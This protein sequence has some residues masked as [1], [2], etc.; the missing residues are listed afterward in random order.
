MPLHRSQG[1]RPDVSRHEGPNSQGR[2]HKGA[3]TECGRFEFQRTICSAR[4]TGVLT[5]LQ[6]CYGVVLEIVSIMLILLVALLASSFLLR[7][8]RLPLPFAQIV[9]GIVL[10][11]VANL[12]VE[13]NP[14]IFFL[15]FLP[16]LLFIDG[17][18]ISRTWRAAP[19]RPRAN[20]HPAR[21][22]LLRSQ[23]CI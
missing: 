11:S 10:G 1:W 22:G 21:A 4:K 7:A 19:L 16:A 6:P 14:E 9:V 23:S 3:H 20:R 13:L 18:R 17:W 15:L 8:S 12:K 2:R 5:R